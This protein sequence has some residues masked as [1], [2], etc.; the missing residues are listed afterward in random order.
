M[1]RSLILWEKTYPR[2]DFTV[3][4][5]L[6]YYNIKKETQ[7]WYY[8]SLKPNKHLLS[9]MPNK[10]L[11]WKSKGIFVDGISGNWLSNQLA[12]RKG[13]KCHVY[14]ETSTSSSPRK[15]TG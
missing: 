9:S 14:V 2:N 6:H 1:A 3:D 10:V 8:F 11:D 5:L 4:H 12:K 7:G 13:P 15:L